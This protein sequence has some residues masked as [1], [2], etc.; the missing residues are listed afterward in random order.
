MTNLW[1]LQFLS[2]QPTLPVLVRDKVAVYSKFDSTSINPFDDQSYNIYAQQ[3]TPGNPIDIVNDFPW[4]KSP[5]T[6]RSD[7]PVIYLTEKRLAINSIVSNLANSTF[8]SVDSTQTGLAIVNNILQQTGAPAVG[9]AQTATNIASNTLKQIKTALGNNLSIIKNATT[10]GN[11]VL[12]PYTYLYLTEQTGFNYAMPYFSDNYVSDKNAFGDKEDGNIFSGV[13]DMASS[14]SEI[15]ASTTGALSPGTY[16]ERSQAFK[17]GEGSSFDVNFPLLNT[18]TFDDISLNWQLLFA[19]IFQNRPGRITRSIIDLPV[20]YELTVPGSTFIPYAYINKLEV[21]FLGSRRM[22]TIP[23]PPVTQS[24]KTVS[25]IKTIIPD[26]YQ[27]S[28]SFTSLNDDTRN[29]LYSGLTRTPVT[30]NGQ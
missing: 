16:I 10:F 27:V 25:T 5:K 19:L 14:V 29:F 11:A 4:T 17:M 1:A 22:M 18:G 3:T 15:L 24:Q 21:K 13:S 9:N 26:A 28:I 8:A 6:S 12:D 20:I 30:V 2:H 23:I 7:T